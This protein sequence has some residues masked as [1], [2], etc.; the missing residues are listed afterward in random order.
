[1]TRFFASM[2]MIE[3]FREHLLFDDRSQHQFV[4][5]SVSAASS[6]SAASAASATP[7][8]EGQPSVVGR[9]LSYLCLEV[10]EVFLCDLGFF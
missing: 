9:L 10:N 7:S 6:A 5:T 2:H 1:M 8:D 4:A 3:R